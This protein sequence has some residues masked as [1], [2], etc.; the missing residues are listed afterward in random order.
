MAQLGDD[1]VYAETG[2][3]VFKPRNQWHTFWNAGDTTCRILEIISPAGFEHFFYELG[4][5]MAETKAVSVAQVAGL[6]EL[7]DRYGIYFRRRASRS[8]AS[9]TLWC[10]RGD[11]SRQMPDARP[12]TL[13]PRPRARKSRMSTATPVS[14]ER[15]E[16]VLEA[17]VEGINT[18]NFETLM[19]L[20][21]PEAA[22]A[23]EPGKLAPGLGGI[24]DALGEFVTL[25][26]KLDL[27]LVLGEWSFAGT[28]PQGE[29]VK[30][31]SRNADVLRRQ[32]DGSWRFVI[33]NPW[34]RTEWSWELGAGS[35]ESGAGNREIMVLAPTPC[36]WPPSSQ[37]QLA[38]M[39]IPLNIVRRVGR[40]R[41]RHSNN[42]DVR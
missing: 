18:R 9:S 28:G 14:T 16:Q 11:S 30:L 29:P 1:V 20:Y 13:D 10:I 31:A 33:D 42:G 41:H 4:E 17:V 12:S 21:E 38:D 40:D 19:Y 32:V 25:N 7:G 15:P 5:R 22:F 24:R 8:S 23:I 2:D 26:G 35:W 3:L 37:L 36:R 39:S 34:E 6:P 27:A